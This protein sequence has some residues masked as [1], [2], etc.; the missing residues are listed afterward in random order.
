MK[1]TR[2]LGFALR[3]LA[4]DWRAGELLLIAVAV[5]VAVAGVTTVGFFTDR[6]QQALSRQANQLLGA[7]LVLSGS[8]LLPREFEAEAFRRALAVTRTMRFP[9]M[10]TRGE[11][12]ELSS[13][14]V[15]TAGYPLRGELRIADALYGS[16]RRA[17]AIPA[18]GTVW[19]DEKLVIQLGVAV[20][21]S[22]GVG[23]S[24]L[25]VSAI[26]TQEPDAAIGFINSGPR[27]FLNEAD[28]AAT[29]LVQPGS[30]VNYR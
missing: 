17:D 11:K 15:V 9:S 19:V 20:G 3:L 8:R 22:V 24:R 21:D 18:A 26:V 14:R 27:V 1:F 25:R 23:A 2:E 6:V 10:V 13:I 4:R 28:L 12:S 30:R 29:G 16:D 5:V 7:D